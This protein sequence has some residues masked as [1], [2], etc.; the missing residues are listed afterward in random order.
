MI[1]RFPASSLAG[2]TLLSL[3]T[4]VC[5]CVLPTA[6]ESTLSTYSPRTDIRIPRDS[7]QS[8]AVSGEESP[9]RE[10][11]S[12][13]SEDF[14]EAR[15]Q[16]VSRP[17]SKPDPAVEPEPVPVE[18][19]ADRGQSADPDGDTYAGVDLS[20]VLLGQE[21]RGGPKQARARRLP[22]E[23]RI[24]DLGIHGEFRGSPGPR[25]ASGYSIDSPVPDYSR[26]PEVIHHAPPPP[27]FHPGTMT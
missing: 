7:R 8:S 15:V 23:L 22:P 4:G 14:E 9:A 21:L 16:E 24:P 18:K 5:G 20:P 26:K 1:A 19:S 12:A 27:R 2:L 10:E 13:P 25:P 17:G 11:T 6:E 3:V